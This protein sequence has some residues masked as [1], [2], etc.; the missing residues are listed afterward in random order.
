[1][2]AFFAPS[3]DLARR[4]SECARPSPLAGEIAIDRFRSI[5]RLPTQARLEFVE[6]RQLASLTETEERAPRE[7]EQV[8]QVGDGVA[9]RPL[10]ILHRPLLQ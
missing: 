10:R 4:L 2:L 7:L 9:A 3:A 8:E 5:T 6:E 1:M